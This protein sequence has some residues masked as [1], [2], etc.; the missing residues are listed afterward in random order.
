MLRTR[1]R[2]LL[3][4]SLRPPA[5]YSLGRAL[6]TTYTLDL[7]ALL[8][9]PLAFTYFSYQDE[10]GEPTRDPVALFEAL[11]RHAD[12]IAIF[13]Q[14]G[15]IAVPKPQLTLLAYLEGSIVQVRARKEGGVFHPKVWLLR[16]EAHPEAGPRP[17]RYRLL[18]LSRNLTFDRAWDTCLLLDGEVE[19]GGGPA[20]RNR[21]LADFVRTLPE[22]AVR[23]VAKGLRDEVDRMADEVLRVRFEPPEPFREVVFH[24]LGL[25]DDEPWPF[26][27]G[28]RSLVV[29]PFLSAGVVERLTREKERAVVVSRPEE[30]EALRPDLLPEETFVLD[31]H[32]ELDA[33]EGAEQERV[34]EEEAEAGAE[35][36]DAPDRDPAATL[37]GLHAKIFLIEYWLHGYL[38][39]GS[40]NATSAAFSRNV[41]LLVELR[42]SRGRCNVDGLLGREG[43]G[44][45][46]DGLR[47]LLQPYEWREPEEDDPIRRKLER[48]ADRLAREIGEAPLSARVGPSVR[49]GDSDGPYAV[50]LRGAIPALP[51]G[52]S[53]TVWPATLPSRLGRTPGGPAERLAR[54]EE[55]SF[56]ALTAFWAWELRLHE[57]DREAVQ[58]F[59]VA[60]PLE[61][62]PADRR[63][64]LVRSLLRDRRRV[65][66]LLLLLLSDEALDVA[67]LVDE[68]GSDGA[69]SWR[70]RAGWDE[71]TLLE[72]LLQSLVGNPRHLEEAA[73]LIEDLSKT[74]EGREL[75]PPGLEEIWRPVW[76]VH[77]R[78]AR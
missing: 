21:P 57:E 40:A 62:A 41:E 37:A 14:A 56:D 28:K 61:N 6:G 52:A 33:Q 73:R 3:L 67:R 49:E 55:V 8:S 2:S 9:A 47:S 29:S 38:F 23:P 12:K 60:V 46:E 22:L 24:P 36:G 34:D 59:V 39:V 31:A 72:T 54:F 64:R 42:A 30:L 69:G 11:R 26:P 76:T 63:E 20:D 53:L 65:L 15:A 71:P 1:E 32:A 77:E 43:D 5:G 68:G 4:E 75:L 13:C 66:R 27:P 51:D 78:R 58:R 70:R 48:A 17:D 16:Y 18:C 25:S 35:A 74:P 7:P 10:E 44:F 45:R 19:E 50:E